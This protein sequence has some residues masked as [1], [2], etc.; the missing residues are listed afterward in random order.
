MLYKDEKYS[1]LD[2]YETGDQF[3]FF[4]KARRLIEFS[5]NFRLVLQ[6]DGTYKLTWIGNSVLIVGSF[7]FNQVFHP[8]GLACCTREAH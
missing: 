4:I 6:T 7:D 3:R 8:R 5:S 1:I 2:Y